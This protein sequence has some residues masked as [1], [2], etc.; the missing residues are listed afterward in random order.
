MMW[1]SKEEKDA[2]RRGRLDIIQDSISEFISES[3]ETTENVRQ[4][5]GFASRILTLDLPNTKQGF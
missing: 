1:N 3:E 5:S 2:G 4:G